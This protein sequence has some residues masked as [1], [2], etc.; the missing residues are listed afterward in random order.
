MAEA[1][2]ESETPWTRRLLL[3]REHQNLRMVHTFTTLEQQAAASETEARCEA[4]AAKTSKRDLLLERR[5]LDEERQECPRSADQNMY[6]ISRLIIHLTATY[7][8]S[9]I[10]LI[11]QNVGIYSSSFSGYYLK[12]K[13]R[14]IMHS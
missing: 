13:K 3:R 9:K 6:I 7:N 5:C 1:I 4:V 11:L 2:F 8:Y 14:Q 10:Y 12:H